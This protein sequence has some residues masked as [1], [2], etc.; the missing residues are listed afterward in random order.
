MTVVGDDG[1]R[2]ERRLNSFQSR[3]CSGDAHGEIE[4][5]DDLRV[6]ELVRIATVAKKRRYDD[7]AA[8]PTSWSVSMR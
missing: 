6:R 3:S 2:G 8:D 5:S 4:G 1:R 7:G